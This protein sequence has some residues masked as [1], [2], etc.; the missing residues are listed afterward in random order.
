MS[1]MLIAIFKMEILIDKEIQMIKKSMY[2]VLIITLLVMLSF[3]YSQASITEVMLDGV[4]NSGYWA[5]D[6]T[7]TYLYVKDLSDSSYIYQWRYGDTDSLAWSSMNDMI[8]ELNN[9]QGLNW[10]LE[11]GGDP[12][13]NPS[14]PVWSSVFLERGIYDVSLAPDSSAYNLSDYWEGND[15]N[16]YV[17]MWADYDDSFNFGEGSNVTTS[18]SNALQFYRDNVDGMRINLQQD[19]NLYFYINDS[20]SVDN[21]GSVKLNVAVAPEPQQVILFISGA[22]PLATWPRRQRI[23]LFLKK[24]FRKS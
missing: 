5:D 3:S 9:Q 4:E 12:F 1:G 23:K 21:A 2:L 22:I 13:N 14:Q 20:N 16:A 10:W 17:Q 6:L 18:E 8:T 11:S 7:S 19:T 24:S 15:W